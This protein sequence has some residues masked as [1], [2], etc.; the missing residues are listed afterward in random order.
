MPGGYFVGIDVPRIRTIKPE[1]LD[2]DKT[3]SLP[4]REWRA[5]VSL[6]TLADDRGHVRANPRWLVGQIFWSAPEKVD[7]YE[8]L[9][10]LSRVGLVVLYSHAGQPFLLV[11]HWKRHQKVDHPAR[12][13]MP[14][15]ADDDGSFDWE[16][17]LGTP[18]F[19]I[20]SR[21]VREILATELGPRTQDLGSRTQ[22]QDPTSRAPREGSG[23]IT[24]ISEL[25]TAIGEW[26]WTVGE[27]HASKVKARAHRIIKAGPIAKHEAEYAKRVTEEQVIPGDRSRLVAY[28]LGVVEGERKTAENEK[29]KTSPP[30]RSKPQ[31]KDDRVDAVFR[32]VAERHRSES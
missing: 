14:Q 19:P 15:L 6:I 4:S 8:V 28:F 20:P 18:L 32:E 7:I 30:P 23:S 13:R 1:I 24:T 12:P 22:A 26:R 29:G 9:A 2:D 5:F 10:N 31:G 27:L 25:E 16:G 11:K 21:P 17:A 3:S